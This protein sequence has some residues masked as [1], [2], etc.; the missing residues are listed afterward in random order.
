MKLQSPDSI[1]VLPRIVT[2]LAAVVR[3]TAFDHLLLCNLITCC[4]E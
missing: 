3:L 1:T 4:I 2:T